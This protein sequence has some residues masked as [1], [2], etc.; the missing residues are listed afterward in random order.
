MP[1][2]RASG[3]SPSGSASSL[4]A[5]SGSKSLANRDRITPPQPPNVSPE[6]FV[7]KFKSFG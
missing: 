1:T 6:K 2:G 7:L 4:P 3:L 5:H